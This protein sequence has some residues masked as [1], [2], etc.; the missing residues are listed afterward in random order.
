VT[1]SSSYQPKKV[2]EKWYKYWIEKGYFHARVDKKLKPFTIVIPPPNIT[3]T[4]HMGH[5]LNDTLQDIFI[6]YKRMRGYNACWI[7]GTDHAGIATQNVVEK[8]L[9]KE[10]KS[11]FDLGRA[12]FIEKVWEWKKKY[13]NRIIA[14][15]EKLG[16][17][18]DWARLNFTLGKEFSGAVTETFVRLY[19]KGLIYRDEYIINWCPRCQTALSDIEVEHEDQKDSLYYIRYPFKESSDHITVATT[20]PETMLGDTA[21]AVNPKDTRFKG[22][23]GKRLILPILN[24]E[25]PLISDSYVDPEFGTGAVKITPAHD[26][27]DFEMGRKHKLPE[28]KVIDNSAKM[29]KAAA[30]YE[31]L[32]RYACRKKLL[33]DLESGGYLEKKEDY[34]VPI[35][36]C[37]RCST[38]IEPLISLQWFLRVKKLA[39]PAIDAVK[40]GEV[41]Y[42]PKRWEKVYLAWMAGLKDWCLSRQIWWGHRIPVW[43]CG[44]CFGER[45]DLLLT[46]KTPED[47]EP[48][49]GTYSALRK[50]GYTHKEI[51]ERLEEIV[52]LP[53]E[54]I[55]IVARKKPDKCPVCGEKNLI[56]D[57]DVLDTWFSSALWPFATLGWPKKSEDLDYFYPTSLLITGHEIIHLW[58]ARMI[59]MGLELMDEVPFSEVYIHGIVRD[60]KGKKM[61]KSLGNVIDPLD[62]IAQYGTDAL[63]FTL[64][65]SCMQGQDLQLFDEKFTSSRNFTNKIWNASRFALMN[66]KDSQPVPAP[67]GI[68]RNLKLADRW[69]LSRYNRV[70][71][72]VTDSIEHHRLSEAAQR[73]YH[74][75]WHEFCDW[76]LEMIKPRLYGENIDP[77]T[78][79]CDSGRNRKPASSIQDSRSRGATQ[80]VIYHILEGV[81]RL[82]HPFMPFI[83]EEIWQQLKETVKMPGS[84][85]GS[86]MISSWPE[87]D[88]TKIAPK[89]EKEAELIIGVITSLRNIRSELGIGPG[90]KIEVHIKA[91]KKLQLEILEKNVGDIKNLAGILKIELGPDIKKPASSASALIGEVEVWVPLKGLIDF[92][93]EGLRLKKQIDK[94]KEELERVEKTLKNK[95]FLAK[96]PEA[97]VTKEKEK[98][99]ELKAK[100]VKL[101][102]NLE[103]IA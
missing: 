52:I 1:I 29:T 92:D 31:G 56:Q 77:R 5:A 102:K 6:R 18:C 90:K 80:Y 39:A 59:Q 38:P 72:E 48:V 75:I 55:P 64:I 17:S 86:V 4:L 81:L 96:A 11:R 9:L 98:E 89:I 44:D 8:A 57:T 43:Y 47:L 70:V 20:R 84:A 101:E 46:K 13:G 41:T 94:I 91:K 74:F 27:N 40:K 61:S 60:K 95:K 49:H 35:G 83:T 93:K 22:L 33:E 23:V 78:S 25:I 28:I 79:D 14:Q 24:R 68:T 21:V 19:K 66:L 50:S 51:V 97:V 100:L 2:E 65:A 99:K 87:F 30:Q 3:G 103:N 54:V 12:S 34:S 15:L 88:R 69:I 62:I 76:Y 82:L 7:P 36:R 26:P 71:K 10:G 73:L 63:R 16:C 42:I 32:D 85:A 45:I 67:K 58:V 37:Y 53:K